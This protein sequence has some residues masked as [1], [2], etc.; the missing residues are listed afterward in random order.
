[1]PIISVRQEQDSPQ[2]QIIDL[3]AIAADQPESMTGRKH[4][5]VREGESAFSERCR[6]ALAE[7]TWPFSL[8]QTPARVPMDSVTLSPTR[9]VLQVVPTEALR[10]RG[11]PAVLSSARQG[12]REPLNIPGA[13]GVSIP[14]CSDGEWLF[15]VHKVGSQQSR[16]LGLMSEHFHPFSGPSL[17]VLQTDV[18]LF[19]NVQ[20]C[21]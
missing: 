18:G 6:N 5:Q 9:V 20:K 13:G 10:V 11:D 16:S 2:N 17:S 8:I 7:P 15:L 14:D 19:W 21:S 4:F 3:D 1:M 12:W